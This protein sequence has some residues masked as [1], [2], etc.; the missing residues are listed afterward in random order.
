[1]LLYVCISSQPSNSRS[2]SR[3]C[4]LSWGWCSAMPYLW[5]KNNLGL[6]ASMG[7]TSAVKARL[8][9]S[10]SRPGPW[11]SVQRRRS[12]VPRLIMQQTNPSAF[13]FS[14]CLDI[15]LKTE[16]VSS[17]LSHLWRTTWKWRAI[18]VCSSTTEGERKDKKRLELSLKQ[19]FNCQCT[20]M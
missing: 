19:V 2:S 8:T 9:L 17:T 3:C 10:S 6:P 12:L 5:M 11:G 14:L 13:W 20:V 4:I 1:M 7:H 15:P 16:S 18:N